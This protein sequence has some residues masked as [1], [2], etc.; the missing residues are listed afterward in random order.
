MKKILE[1]LITYKSV[2]LNIKP[3]YYEYYAALYTQHRR[4][5]QKYCKFLVEF[6]PTPGGV[7]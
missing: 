3:E 7:K 2:F 4:S 1:L 6:P 5:V